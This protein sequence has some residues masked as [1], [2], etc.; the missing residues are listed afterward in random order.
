LN[1]LSQCWLLT[2]APTVE[3][4][5][6]RKRLLPCH[7]RLQKW[8]EMQSRTTFEIAHLGVDRKRKARALELLEFVRMESLAGMTTG[9]FQR[10]L[11]LVGFKWLS[12]QKRL[13]C[14]NRL[15]DISLPVS[16][17]LDRVPRGMIC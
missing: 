3:F 13:L 9:L 4:P 7:N 8:E 2:I 16:N 15:M 11:A 17:R 1:D 6:V 12:E 14:H 10:G 5:T